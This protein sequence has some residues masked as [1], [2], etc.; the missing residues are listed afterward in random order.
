MAVM[1]KDL[2]SS[3]PVAPKSLNSNPTNPYGLQQGLAEGEDYAHQMDAVNEERR[4]KIEDENRH[5]SQ[6][7]ALYKN[8][9]PA[10][11]PEA[12]YGAGAGGPPGAD[13]MQSSRDA[14]FA[15]AKDKAGQLAASSLT[16]LRNS[17]SANNTLGSGIERGETRRVLNDTNQNL[18]ET[19]REQAVQEVG[20]RQHEADTQYQGQIT[21]RG[22]N[23]QARQ[24]SLAAL[25]QQIG[26]LY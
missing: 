14:I 25:A 9:S 8:L 23:L 6:M 15:R 24:A 7:Q 11:E 12:Q 17:M 4:R 18:G 2:Y 20:Q 1:A 13:P 26:A 3:L 10:S 22:Q 16:A 21:Q 19:V 5:I